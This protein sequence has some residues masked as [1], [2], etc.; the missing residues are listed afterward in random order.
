MIG[1]RHKLACFHH[2]KGAFREKKNNQDSM[3]RKELTEFF[4]NFFQTVKVLPQKFERF[5]H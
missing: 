3:R 1:H 5:G 4:M 2:L